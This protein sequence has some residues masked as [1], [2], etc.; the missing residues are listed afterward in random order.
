[1]NKIKYNK[2]HVLRAKLR[3]LFVYFKIIIKK[4]RPPLVFSILGANVRALRAYF[5]S[6]GKSLLMFERNTCGRQARD[7]ARPPLSSR[8]AV[9]RT[10]LS[11]GLSFQRLYPLS[12]QRTFLSKAVPFT[13]TLK[14]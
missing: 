13:F 1:M 5:D 4:T 12:F 9:G 10:L 11:K 3:V 2:I 7:A 6:M 8:S 14:G